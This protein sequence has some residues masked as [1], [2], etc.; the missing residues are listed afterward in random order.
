MAICS[1]TFHIEH[2][3]PKSKGGA[4]DES[5]L[6]LA[7]ASCNLRKSNQ[8]HAADPKT[9][10]RAL[11]FHPVEQS[12]K[13]HFCLKGNRID[14]TSPAGRA[15]AAFLEFNSVRRQAARAAWRLTG[16]WP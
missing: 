1:Y 6:A 14:G 7:C 3:V 5:N 9:G 12:W 10:K 16:L 13:E 4:S 2:C 15:T 8:T 11:L